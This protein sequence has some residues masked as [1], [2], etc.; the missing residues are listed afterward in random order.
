MAIILVCEL[1]T[2][3]SG[4]SIFRFFF[5]RCHCRCRCCQHPSSS[6]NFS[7]FSSWLLLKHLY[8]ILYKTFPRR[9]SSSCW[10]VTSLDFALNFSPFVSLSL[11]LP[12]SVSST[13]CLCF[14]LYIS[15]PSFLPS[16]GLALYP[17]AVVQDAHKFN[18]L[19][20]VSFRFS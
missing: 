5:C 7:H 14:F 15:A 9:M 6:L 17:A 19:L 12:L 4:H 8:H 2:T 16:F 18:S 11:S 20:F 1:D 13:R 10:L 3:D